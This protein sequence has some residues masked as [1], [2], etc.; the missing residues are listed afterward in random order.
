MLK[1]SQINYLKSCHRELQRKFTKQLL[2]GFAKKFLEDFSKKLPMEFQIELVGKFSKKK[3]KRRYSRQNYWRDSKAHFEGIAE[4]ID[5]W[6]SKGI[7]SL[8]TDGKSWYWW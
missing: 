4:V 8:A 3:K 6:N 2:N 1:N 7:T 5:E